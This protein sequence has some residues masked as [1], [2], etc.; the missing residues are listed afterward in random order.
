[1]LTTETPPMPAIMFQDHHDR[2]KPR[3][4]CGFDGVT[5]FEWQGKKYAARHHPCSKTMNREEYQAEAD[6]KIG[7]IYG[8]TNNH[9]WPPP[10]L[11]KFF[12]G[13]RMARYAGIGT[14]RT[15]EWKCGTF[16]I[17]N[18]RWEFAD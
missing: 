3:F 1:M 16:Q 11:M 17:E 18:C 12:P 8:E 2:T 9:D 7:C 6:A 13:W 5:E 4:Y 14:F 10:D 15:V